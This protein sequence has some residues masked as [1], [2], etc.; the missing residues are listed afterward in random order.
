MFYLARQLEAREEMEQTPFLLACGFGQ[1]ECVEVL[2]AAGC[3]TAATDDS[4][5]TGL[6]KAAFHGHTAVVERLVAL[7]VCAPYSFGVPS[8]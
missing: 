1:V 8:V 3:D 7:E 2:V 5:F 4:G 6:I